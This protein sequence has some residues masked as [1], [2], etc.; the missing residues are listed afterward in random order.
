MNSLCKFVSGGSQLKLVPTQ[1]LVSV[2]LLL[3]CT[4]GDNTLEGRWMHLTTSKCKIR[5]KKI[6]FHKSD[7][8]IEMFFIVMLNTDERPIPVF[9]VIHRQT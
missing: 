7:V 8:L 4:E 5:R 1:F 3:L 2:W 6:I 9:L